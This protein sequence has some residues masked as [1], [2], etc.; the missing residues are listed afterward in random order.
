MET[1]GL[2]YDAF[3]GHAKKGSP[4]ESFLV[5]YGLQKSKRFSVSKFGM[6][7]AQALAQG[8]CHRMEYFFELWTESGDPKYKFT[9]AD[10]AGYSPPEKVEQ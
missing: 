6:E 8:W 9:Q 3:M 10:K 5:Q 4:G 2:P 7:E 1:T